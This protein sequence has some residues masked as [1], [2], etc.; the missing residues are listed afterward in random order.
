MISP[1]VKKSL[2]ILQKL[3][4]GGLVPYPRVLNDF[5]LNSTFELFPHP[6]FPVLKDLNE[7]IKF[8]ESNKKMKI[9]KKTSLLLLSLMKLVKP[10][11]LE[12]MSL[13]I[14][15]FFDDNLEFLENKKEEYL[16]I[17]KIYLETMQRELKASYDEKEL[18]ENANSFYSEDNKN[19]INNSFKLYN[20]ENIRFYYCKKE[21]YLKNKYLFFK[22]KTTEDI[23][24]YNQS[25][26]PDD[27]RFDNISEVLNFLKQERINKLNNKLDINNENAIPR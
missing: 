20:I 19:I 4:M 1:S 8:S 10:S 13:K 21:K 25:K 2:N 16:R 17:H 23:F 22:R 12:K 11:S 14:D 7:P 9:N 27:G 3:Y 6:P 18:I 24:L 15:Y 5:E 26:S